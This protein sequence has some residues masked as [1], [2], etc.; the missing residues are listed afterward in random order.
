[1]R[2]RTRKLFLWVRVSGK[3]K[4]SWGI[5]SKKWN[6]DVQIS[7]VKYFVNK[8]VHNNNRIWEL[9]R[10]NTLHITLSWWLAQQHVL[11]H[12]R[13][14]KGLV[15]NYSCYLKE[16]L[17]PEWLSDIVCSGCLLVEPGV[18]GLFADDRGIWPWLLLG[19]QKIA[20]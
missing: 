16:Y 5:W 11:N 3:G 1:M 4:P 9:E 2:P 17:I 14:L 6:S 12:V 18:S 10:D 19:L 20:S 7:S 8:N 13:L 15:S